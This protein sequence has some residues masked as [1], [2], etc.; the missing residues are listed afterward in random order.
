MNAWGYKNENPKKNIHSFLVI[1]LRRKLRCNTI[2]T[3]FIVP[4]TKRQLLDTLLNFS[5]TVILYFS[6]EQWENS[7]WNC[8]QVY[9]SRARSV[10]GTNCHKDAES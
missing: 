10:V 7:L 6:R 3:V 1:Y 5:V 4:L 9:T 2:S 8:T